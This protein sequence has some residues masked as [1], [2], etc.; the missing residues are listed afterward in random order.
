MER[1]HV[2]SQSSNPGFYP[3]FLGTV[4]SASVGWEADVGGPKQ[5]TSKETKTTDL[6]ESKN[7]VSGF[8]NLFIKGKLFLNSN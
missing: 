4:H 8:Y 6:F 5:L 7:L 2:Q 3:I 1:L